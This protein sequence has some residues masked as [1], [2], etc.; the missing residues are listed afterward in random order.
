MIA[1]LQTHWVNVPSRV[2]RLL[3]GLLS[4]LEL[5][6]EPCRTADGLIDATEI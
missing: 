1:G 6:P 2:F 3:H 4:R 5:P